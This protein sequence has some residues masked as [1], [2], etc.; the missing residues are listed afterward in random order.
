M[1]GY[2]KSIFPNKLGYF[3]MEMVGIDDNGVEAGL[4]QT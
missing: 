2:G 1:H 4:C 3:F